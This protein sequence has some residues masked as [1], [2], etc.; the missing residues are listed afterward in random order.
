MDF[1]LKSGIL[2][3]IFHQRWWEGIEKKEEDFSCKKSASDVLFTHKNSLFAVSFMCNPWHQI[4]WVERWWWG[5]RNKRENHS[6]RDP[7]E[8]MLHWILDMRINEIS[9][10]FTGAFVTVPVDRK[11]RQWHQRHHLHLVIKD[12][13]ASP[14][15]GSFLQRLN[16]FL[17]CSS[18]L[19]F[20]P[21]Y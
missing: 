4:W 1:E 15:L 9:A 13:V 6:G 17:I 7:R 3:M 2:M 12:H 21:R 5:K 14:P 16:P 19:S 10:K 18:P 11:S 20:F 8:N